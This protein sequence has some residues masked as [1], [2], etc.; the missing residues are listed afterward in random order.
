M[1]MFYLWS[2]VEACLQTNGR[3][4]QQPPRFQGKNPVGVRMGMSA[5]RLPLWEYFW[6]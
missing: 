5:A 1:Q 4:A 2:K 6:K 3:N